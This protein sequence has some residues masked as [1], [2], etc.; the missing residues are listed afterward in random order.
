MKTTKN[1]IFKFL[2]LLPF[3]VFLSGCD[4][5]EQEPQSILEIESFYSTGS[6]AEMGLVGV[7]NRFF[8]EAH[9]VGTFMILDISSDDLTTPPPRFGYLL[10]N[11]DEMSALNNDGT[12]GYFNAPWVTIANVNLLIEKVSELPPTAFVGETTA[13]ENRKDEILGEA[14]FIRGVSYYYLAMLWRNVPLILEFP[15][16]PLPQDNQ[17]PNST[18][19][20][21]LAQ[22]KA[23]LMLAASLLPDVLTQF[24]PHERRGRASKAAANA[25]LS[26]FALMEN[27]WQSVVDMSNE[28]LS[29]TQYKLVDPW[30]R[31]FL[32]EQNSN[33]AILEIQAERS[34]G[35]FNMGIHGWFYGGGQF[36]AT[37][38]AVAQFEKPLKDARYEFTIHNNGNSLKFMPV[39]LWA[40]AGIERA[41]LTM[42][43]L[44]EIY[45]NKAEAL[46]ELNYDLYKQ[47]V[48]DI[49]NEIR[50]RAADP[51][52]QNRLRPTAPVGTTG[53]PPLTLAELDTQDK[54]RQ[55]IRA[56]KRRELMFE[57][58][59]WL[60]LLRWD[61]VYAMDVVNTTH[62][63]R[64]YLPIPENEITVNNGVLQQNPG[65]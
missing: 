62:P 40:D 54:M 4:V 24:T 42:I 25:Y 16:G 36:K 64:L 14:Y 49:L 52:F 30:T 10:E 57:G 59:R 33:E 63:G 27:N 32:N 20:Q 61:P 9:I 60:D 19:E 46:N 29:N 8:A 12:T 53:I 39:P 65:W 17:V 6:E 3:C 44:A 47:D 41:N 23:D 43:R 7:Y 11:R 55:A 13:N 1:K 15:E 35:F 21:V 5:L 26:R 58:T 2:A 22:A 38:D 51:S 18:Q 45:F 48:L 56:E 28:I 34:P 50:A 31:L 37:P